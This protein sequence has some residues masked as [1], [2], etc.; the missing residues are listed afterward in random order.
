M[1]DLMEAGHDLSI[2][3]PEGERNVAEV[4]S[5]QS[6]NNSVCISDEFMAAVED[7]RDWDLTTRVTGET[8]KT[9]GARDLLRNVAEAAWRCA[10]PRRQSQ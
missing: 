9:V 2:F 5:F 4:T 6:A 7:D 3:T 10:D 1:V 8:V